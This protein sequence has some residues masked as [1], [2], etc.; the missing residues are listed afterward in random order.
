MTTA[1]LT[2]DYPVIIGNV[3]LNSLEELDEYQKK[4]SE[5][6]KA[7]KDAKKASKANNPRQMRN[8]GIE[9]C[10]NNLNENNDILDYF[11]NNFQENVS[12]HCVFLKETNQFVLKVATPKSERRANPG[13]S[14]YPVL[15]ADV[16]YQSKLEAIRQLINVES[17]KECKTK[18]EQESM[19]VTSGFEFTEV[20]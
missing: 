14:G 8:R 6:I 15:I 4:L 19:L 20:K 16:Q 10:V 17:A 13:R 9:Q 2:V 1:E 3:I 7:V 5:Q 12:I 11:S 18:T